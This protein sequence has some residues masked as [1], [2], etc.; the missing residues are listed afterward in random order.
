MSQPLFIRA[1]KF[2]LV[3][4]LFCSAQLLAEQNTETKANH[5]SLPSGPGSLEGLGKS[6]E[7][8]L[9]TGGA[10]YSVDIAVP[11]GTAGHA[12]SVALNYSS[13]FGQGIAGLGWQLSLPSIER[14]LE[15]GQPLYADGDV[16]TY[17]G[18]TL[19]ALTDSTYAPA[20]QT[21]FIRFT[22]D[23]NRFTAL[24]KS[25][26]RYEFGSIVDGD[27]KTVSPASIGPDSREFHGTYKWYLK[28]LT[29]A[30]GQTTEYF[31]TRS[32]NSASS[33][34]SLDGVIYLEKI[35]YG[36]EHGPFN[37]IQFNY[38][39]RPDIY[40]N[41]Q[42]G[43]VQINRQRLQSVDVKHGERLLWS[44]EL[45]YQAQGNDL[46]HPQ[47]ETAALR[48]G[49]SLLRKVTRWN[50]DKT[51][52]LPPIRF[53]YS[54]IYNQDQDF[55]PLGNFPGDEDIDRNLNGSNDI[56]NVSDLEGLPTGINVIGQ[57][58]SFTDV[59]KDGLPDWLY[60][61]S[62][63]YY[64]AKNLGSSPSSAGSS[65][66]N[67][68]FAAAYALNHAPVAPMDDSNVH[69]IDLNGDGQADFLH[70]ISD[71]RWLYYQNRGDGQFS[72]SVAY[73]APASIRPGETGVQ[74]ADINMDQRID[75]ISSS[76]KYWRYCLNGPATVDSGSNSKGSTY[77][78][79]F[80]PFDNFPSIEDID[81]NG[82]GLIDLPNWQC[83]GSL[84]TSLPAEI[85]LTNTQVK[86]VDMN[87]DRLKDAVW[88]REVND[89]I[90]VTYWPHMGS[91]KFAEPQGISIN[92]PSIVGL[93]LDKLKLQDINGDGRADLVYV[94]PGKVKFWLQQYSE[95]GLAWA[96]TQAISAP[97][98]SP[99]STALMEGDLNGNGTQDFAWVSVSS[100]ITPSY[101][102]VSGDTK[103]HLLSVID[104][105]MGLR[106]QLSFRSMGNL[107][108]EAFAQGQAWN[109]SSPVAQQVV[110]KRSFI[111]PL[112]TTGNGEHDRVEQTYT[113]RDAYYDPYK[114]QF[115]GFSFARV[116]TLGDS[117]KG[118]QVSRHFFHTGAPD[119]QD[120]DGD[121]Q[122]DERELDGSTEELPLKGKTLRLE[123][124]SK[125]INLANNETATP[126]QLVQAVQTDW[127][128]RRIHS[129]DTTVASMSG[130]EVTFVEKSKEQTFYHELTNNGKV[131]SRQHTYDD[132][133][134][135]TK[136]IDHGLLDS[137]DD[138][139]TS[140]FE[141]ATHSN[142]IFQLPKLSQVSN[143]QGE[144]LQGTQTYYD[145]L[146]LGQLTRGLT[147]TEQRWQQDQTWLTTQSTS[148]D[149]Y[150]N[151]ILLIDGDGRRRQ[152][153]W[154]IQWHGFPTEEWIF[155]NGF[156]KE[157]LR[158]KADYDT[159]LGVL[160][161]HTGFNGEQ[162]NLT[163][164]SFGRLLTIKKPY[165]QD[166]SIQ[167]SYHFV[168]PFRQLEYY[169]NHNA[170]GQTSNAVDSTSY[171]QTVIKRDDGRTE[172]VK[173][174][175]DGLGRE[176]ATYTKYEQGYIVT[177]SKWFDHQGRDVKTFRPWTTS[178]STYVLPTNDLISTTVD[179][180]AHGRPLVETY[181]ADDLGRR[182]IMTYEYFPRRLKSTDPEGFEQEQTLNAQ[183]KILSL[184]QQQHVSDEL[185]WKTSE[186]LYDPLDRLTKIT[187][188][189]GNVK[190]QRF[191][192]LDHKV[193]QSDLDQ[194]TS[195]YQY[196]VAGNLQHKI[197]QLG[198]TLY[199]QYD[200]AG[201]L[202]DILANDYSPLFTYHY[203]APQASQGYQSGY[204]GKLTWVE[205]FSSFGQAGNSSS[206]TNSEHYHY[207]LR[208]NLIHKTRKLDNVDYQFHYQYDNQDRI[209]RQVW[210]DGDFLKY[211]YDLRGKVKSIGEL[212]TDI[213]YHT[214]GQ[215]DTIY[216][217][218]G[219][220][221]NRAYDDKGQLTSL[222]S[223]G[224][225]E[226]NGNLLLLNYGYDLRGN[227]LRND[228]LLNSSSSQVFEYDAISQLR[229]A[230]GSYGQLRYQYDGIGNM[231][232]KLLDSTTNTAGV[233][234]HSL[235]SMKYGGSAFSENRLQKGGQPG[236]HAITSTTDGKFWNYNGLGQRINDYAG[237]HYDWDQ[238]GRLNQWQRKQADQQ[239][240]DKVIK[241][242]QYLYDF[243]GRRL[244]KTAFAIDASSGNLLPNKQVSYIDKSYE[245]RDDKTQ[246]HI[247][248]G[249]LRV[250]RLETPIAQALAQ[251]KE[252]S[253]NPGWNQVFLNYT[254]E[255][256]SL[257]Q[258][259]SGVDTQGQ[260]TDG[261]KN[262]A[263][264]I[265][266]FNAASQNYQS[267]I[268]TSST[269]SG[270]LSTLA[271]NQ[272]Y[273]FKL[274]AEDISYPFTWRSKAQ[275]DADE[276]LASSHVRLLQ[277]GWNQTSLPLDAAITNDGD[278]ERYI[279]GTSI[280]RIWYYQ[281]SQ[282]RWYAYYKN[283]ADQSTLTELKPDAVYW[284]LSSR[285]QI[286]TAANGSES[287][288]SSQKAYL[289][290]N[291]L[292]SVAFETDESG[293]VS[294]ASL[295]QPYGASSKDSNKASQKV[296]TYSF[297]GKEEDGSG[298]YYFEARYYDPVTT[299]FVSPDPLFAVDMDKCIE[300]IIECNLYQY[301]GNNPV[302][303]VDP[304]GK[305]VTVWDALNAYGDASMAAGMTGIVI[306]EPATTV[307]GAVV[308]SSGALAKVI[309]KVG[310]K[311][312]AAL[313]EVGK[314]ALQTSNWVKTATAKL[315]SG[316]CCFVEGTLVKTADGS[317]AI[318]K[319]KSGSLV[320]SR[321]TKT[322]IT[323]L[324]SVTQ[325]IITKGKPIFQITL[326]D[327][328]GAVEN[329]KV[330][331]NHPF[332]VDGKGWVNTVDLEVGMEIEQFDETTI[333]VDEIEFL[334]STPNTYNLTVDE[335]HSYFA[336]RQEALVHNC[337]C[338]VASKALAKSLESTVGARPLGGFQAAHIIPTS[339]FKN[340]TLAVQ[341]AIKMARTK[342][343][344]HLGA[345][346]RNTAINGF[347]AKTGH[348]GTH[349]NKFFL[350]LGEA[351]A[352]MMSEASTIKVMQN[353][354]KRVDSGEFVKK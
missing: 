329:I 308:A 95:Q 239:G 179:L 202:S 51:V 39:A 174:H 287:G 157:P 76:G 261:I 41:Y 30:K 206:L 218:N 221:Q 190:E 42:A 156:D 342:F 332:W 55:P 131:A 304:T 145:N 217:A 103:A 104:N 234:T 74:F 263:D 306:P 231:T 266:H 328:S 110:S 249:N 280:E 243:K 155:A 81:L 134:N 113:Y 14:S 205:E 35:Q 201:R 160:K 15:N 184:R 193:W 45:S 146:P 79:D 54:R 59:T 260:T 216:Y 210:P 87:G 117:N 312:P 213:A 209:K 177:N 28:K 61:K 90:T 186:F 286:L 322:G 310:P 343:D 142:G 71:A 336:G 281:Q 250:A 200:Q 58:A 251:I 323:E 284:V 22:R 106:T 290:N 19:V 25:G 53:D 262:K 144:L 345:D 282:D 319:I 289:H 353:L 238:L 301:T 291:H 2:A 268:K 153:V 303:F 27:R 118:T 29:D 135:V 279:K 326:L 318:D 139:K 227:M 73:P 96:D 80:A 101:L 13:G 215:V 292:G 182:S 278:I 325:T 171:V 3:G 167:Y 88:L 62:G 272:V 208:G 300:S 47:K 228:D 331:D 185:V 67:I 187:D 46:L 77:D 267:Y 57:Q 82:N 24:D 130:K 172:E 93:Q 269:A 240:A 1:C 237:N 288:I 162:T 125:A 232:S 107:Q 170:Q 296:S 309:A 247:S 119:G 264:S 127:S 274:K 158:I 324:R 352:G 63:Q 315:F 132:W 339:D 72:P 86:M 43:F 241:Q 321:D 65:N 56:N 98:Y 40:E 219:T 175:I 37:S 32:S 60:W 203:D 214:D 204:K 116:E 176:L 168:D 105:G 100:D 196:D 259:L 313:N 94:Q 276:N 140:D 126:E 161:A 212:V 242:E 128:L 299:R 178:L 83:S 8:S 198:R 23:D 344:T 91:L 180:D 78:Q 133:G 169:F 108:A 70:R 164:D 163:Y 226:N 194:G 340:R 311:V 354:A 305:S 16:L 84:Q 6:F 68:S 21:S 195:T 159:G 302:N 297:S 49:L 337:A 285:E 192:G 244:K 137:L 143:S 154:D 294:Q 4:L 124:T 183:D 120:N 256:S 85:N 246:K 44:Y 147:S 252:H 36:P 188:A 197:D 115:R 257:L 166:A 230:T 248:I 34:P 152:L 31:Y 223:K 18:E 48:S 258:Q 123:Q 271:A 317:K 114:K 26:N 111:L 148:Y 17:Q 316:C 314:A 141:Y 333:V 320:W 102:D 245:I 151:P 283:R 253:L 295:Y 207:D 173:Q 11:A 191:N 350:A 334:G 330:T 233:T 235:G 224:G 20:L 10:S 222:A 66:G 129:I 277:A 181:P 189:S 341:N 75:I 327:E 5:I 89:Q 254:P 121:G 92:N 275:S 7:P 335:N 97:N 99:Q 50:S 52:S 199:Y 69:L 338:G 9:N 136:T 64:V 38:Q 298:L 149:S 236:P 220:Q 255:G 150:G 122:V 346:A 270:D 293:A 229:K 109:V 33:G 307:V 265:I 347:W 112:D 273:W 351:S 138:N 211:Q 349:T 12:P 348:L 225:S 165:E